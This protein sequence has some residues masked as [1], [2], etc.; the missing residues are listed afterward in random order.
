VGA[1]TTATPLF[2]VDCLWRP[3]RIAAA[4][5][6]C[7]RSGEWT[8]R[9]QLAGPLQSRQRDRVAPVRLDALA[10]TFRDQGRSDH[11]IVVAE[12]LDLATKPVSIGPASKQ[13]CSP[14]SRSAGL[15]IVRSIGNRLFSTSPR[16]RTSPTPAAFRDRDGVLLLG[17]IKSHKNF[18]MFSHGP[19]SVYEARLRFAQTTLVLNCTKG[20]ATGSSP[21]I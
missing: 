2:H 21:R 10:R 14:S 5:P 13:T 17:D 9:C 18:A 6:V 15:P 19:S 12:R 20:R 8:V 16:N 7:P 3:I 1:G 11:H 4:S